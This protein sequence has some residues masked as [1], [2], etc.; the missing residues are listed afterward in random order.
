MDK[1]TF[2]S[3]FKELKNQEC[4]TIKRFKL[5]CDDLYPCLEDDTGQTLFDGHYIYHTAWAARVLAKTK[6]IVHVDISSSLYFSAIVSGFV[7]VKFFDYRPADLRL[8]NLTSQHADLL[9]LPFEDN[10]I[11]SLSC[12]HVIEHIGLGRYGDP[13]CYNGD[14]KALSEIKRVVARGGSILLVVPVG[15][16]RICYNAHRI[17]AFQQV[18]ELFTDCTLKEYAIVP[19]NQSLGLLIDLPISIVNE[20]KYACG[21]FWFQKN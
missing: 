7:P 17:Y 6:P 10:S 2:V 8:S 12:M 14:L 9:S 16:P 21:C 20:Q 15:S 3:Y 13:V 5:E 18:L 1:N 19:D 4:C 11:S